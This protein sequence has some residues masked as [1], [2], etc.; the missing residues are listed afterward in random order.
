MGGAVVAP[1]RLLRSGEMTGLSAHDKQILQE[2]YQ[3]KNLIDLRSSAEAEKSP[4]DQIPGAA[5]Y[6]ID[7]LKNAGALSQ[8]GAQNLNSIDSLGQLSH[9]M[10]HVY[11]MLIVDPAAQEGYR[12]LIDI[13]LDT[14]AGAS[15]FH[16]FAGKDRT[17]MGAAIILH[18]LGVASEDI[19]ADYMRTN[20]L[21]AATRE[22][23][24]EVARQNGETDEALAA[25]A[26]ALSV[27]PS[28]LQRAYDEAEQRYGSFDNYIQ[29]ALGVTAEQKE[30]L[31]CMYLAV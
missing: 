23:Y 5:Y 8:P 19:W 22:A 13:L 6:H 26:S 17:G 14:S 3:L 21:Y 12:K 9:F 1:G 4:D 16:C 7:I 11:R 25:M 29:Q 2:H 31:R 24:L 10:E 20:E 30:K 15:L 18:I 27:Q 28:F